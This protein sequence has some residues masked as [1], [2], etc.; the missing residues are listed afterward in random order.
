MTPSEEGRLSSS[1]EAVVDLGTGVA[2]GDCALLGW[3]QPAPEVDDTRTLLDLVD[4]A[5]L[6]VPIGT[7]MLD[8]RSRTGAPGVTTRSSLRT[9]GSGSRW[10][11]RSWPT[12]ASSRSSTS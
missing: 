3:R 12:R 9:S 5:G 7:W 10:H 2:I 8:R 4:E 6:A 1:Y 11:P